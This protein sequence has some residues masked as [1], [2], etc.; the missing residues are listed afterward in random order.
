MFNLIINGIVRERIFNEIFFYVSEFLIKI[1]FGGGN[2]FWTG[3]YV[4]NNCFFISEEAFTF[5]VESKGV[6]ISGG[7]W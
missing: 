6:I 5:E 1:Y 2:W 7:C 3:D 4:I